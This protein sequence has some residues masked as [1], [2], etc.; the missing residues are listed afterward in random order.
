MYS[1]PIKI[2]ED[3]QKSFHQHNLTITINKPKNLTSHSAFDESSPKK[4]SSKR[5]NRVSATGL[6]YHSSNYGFGT[7]MPSKPE[8]K[9]LE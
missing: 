2:T 9:T 3:S 5:S 1:S 8:I 6:K 4:K 7:S